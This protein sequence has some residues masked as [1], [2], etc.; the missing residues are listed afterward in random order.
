[1]SLIKINELHPTYKKLYDVLGENDDL[2][3]ALWE[4]MGGQQLNLPEHIYDRVKVQSIIQEKVRNGE[5]IDINK[6]S[7]TY[8]Y[9]R[10]WIRKII[11]DMNKN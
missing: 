10:R 6:E 9:S 7:N 8:G 11:T 2:V 3:Y 1:M 5:Q 4:K